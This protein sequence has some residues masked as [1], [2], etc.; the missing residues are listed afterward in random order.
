MFVVRWLKQIFLEG[1]VGG[2]FYVWVCMSVVG[3]VG[4][5]VL[6]GDDG[7]GQGGKLVGEV[8]YKQAITH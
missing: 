3:G 7:H 4:M 6:V 2:T 5:S 1:S 8:A